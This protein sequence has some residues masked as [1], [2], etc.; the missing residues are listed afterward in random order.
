VHEGDERH[1]RETLLQQGQQALVQFD[2]YE[3]PALGVEA[4]GQFRCQHT[5]A[6]PHLDHEIG[7]LYTGRLGDAWRHAVVAQK[8]LAERFLGAYFRSIHLPE[9][10]PRGA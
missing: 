8:V 9:R 4:R 3:P 5:K 7:G 10:P 2:G 6:R 1:C